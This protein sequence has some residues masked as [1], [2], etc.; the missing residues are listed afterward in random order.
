MFAIA[1]DQKLSESRHRSN[2]VQSEYTKLETEHSNSVRQL[3]MSTFHFPALFLLIISSLPAQ[4][5]DLLQVYRQ[6]QSNDPTFEAARFTF[7]SAQQK[8]PQARA[9]LL[10]V[11]NINGNENNNYASSSFGKDPA[12]YR[13]INSWSLSL[14]VTQ[15]L[16]RAQNYYAYS[17]SELMV[18]QARAQLEQAEHD[19]ILRVTQAY[20][21]VLIA[22]ESIEVA[23]KQLKAAEEQLALAIHGFDAGLNA[24]TDIHEAKSRAELA[25]SQRIATLNDLESKHAELEKILGQE[26]NTLAILRPEVSIPKPQPENSTAWREQAREN[27]PAVLA[28]QAALGAAEAAVSKN[29]AEHAPTLDLVASHGVDYSS[30]SVST[31]SDFQTNTHSTKIGVQ[32]TVPLF[33]GGGPNSRVTEAIA[34]AGR[35]ASELEIAR[36]KSGTDAKQAYSAIVNGMAQ[37]E[38]LESAVTSGTSAVK[39]KLTG[40]KLGVNMIIDVLNAEQELYTSQRDL[41]KARY[42]T[43][44]QGFKLKAAAGILSEQDVW[45]VNQLL[46]H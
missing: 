12:V 31:P 39:G 14:Q 36:R 17:E 37:I 18:E 45:A 35:A 27:N 25:R 42:E 16:F 26:T 15:P 34:N 23:D 22:Q 30:G 13:E 9:G 8:L 44:L 5:A 19:L 4:A 41:L 33:A 32:F 46:Q 40:Y 24:I 10:P 1:N 2:V 43:L 11:I 21:D 20:F 29:R 3:F 6:A 28:S 7:A 38:A